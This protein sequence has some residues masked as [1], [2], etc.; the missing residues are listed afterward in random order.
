M[1]VLVITKVF[2]NA[3]QPLSS[4]FNRQ[5]FAALSR[6]CHVEILATIP[7]FPGAGALSKWS[8]AGKLAQVPAHDVIDGM[9]V[10]HPR[11]L[12]LPRYGYAFSGALYAA[13]LLR[14][15]WSRRRNIDVVLGSWAYP[16]GAAAVML[17]DLIKVPCVVKLHGSDI[18]VVARMKGPRAN[19]KWALPRARK[20]IAVS[21]ALAQEVAALG[22]PRERVAI[23]QNGVDSSLFHPRDRAAAKKQLGLR[24]GKLILYVGRLERTK[25][26]IDLLDAFER[27]KD[28]TLALVG[29][30]AARA[31]VQARKSD[32]ILVPGGRPLEEIPLWM[33]AADVVALPS[34]NEGTPNVIL[35]AFACGRPVV[36]SDVGGIPDLIDDRSLGELHPVK[37]LDAIAAS[38][39]R[40]AAAQHDADA[41]AKRGARGG[42]D[43]SA[44]KLYDVLVDACGARAAA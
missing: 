2:P 37:D 8:S 21:R 20:I 42:W 18:N 26:V 12:F 41:I 15:V 25:G 31:E 14:D 29:D 27:T 38:L 6:L 34:W 33:A 13:S 32:R 43:A 28:L 16:D 39:M 44:R 11:T 5:Q 24:D 4:P 7:W 22:V 23:V 30:G 10:S 40:V 19:L 1:R 17:A 35:E 3:A 9:A 36:A